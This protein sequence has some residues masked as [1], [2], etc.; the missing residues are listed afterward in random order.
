[1]LK[2]RATVKRPKIRPSYILVNSFGN[3]KKRGSIILQA[4]ENC[5]AIA[6][7]LAKDFR[8]NIYKQRF[9]LV[10]L[11]RQYLRSKIRKGLDKRVL[12][13][14][15]KYV[16]N[17][18]AIQT[19]YG[20]RIGLRDTYRYDKIGKKTKKLAYVLLQLWLEF[21][22]KNMPARAHWRPQMRMWK[23]RRKE[24]GLR[25]KKVVGAELGKLLRTS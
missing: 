6:K 16:R 5:F 14:T 21:G 19:P 3:T 13:A 11:T 12:I 1:V 20:A 9:K 15:K 10:P 7:E 22:T 25:L 23:A 17:I 2:V 24:F 4:R 8:A 18:Q